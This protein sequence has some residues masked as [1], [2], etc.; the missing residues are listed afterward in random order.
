MLD[1]N[2]DRCYPMIMTTTED[3]TMDSTKVCEDLTQVQALRTKA[4]AAGDQAQV[5]LCDRAIAGD[6]AALRECARVIAEAAAQR[7][8]YH[9]TRAGTAGVYGHATRHCDEAGCAAGADRFLSGVDPEQVERGHVYEI[10]DDG[11]VIAEII[12]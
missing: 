1:E 3:T 9:V 5:A 10:D 4:G 2:Q 12:D 7:T 8:S 11:A 6:E